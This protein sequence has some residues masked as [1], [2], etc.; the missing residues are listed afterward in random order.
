MVIEIFNKTIEAI[1]NRGDFS[2]MGYNSRPLK[3][4]RVK[5]IVVQIFTIMIVLVTAMYIF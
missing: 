3:I 4:L 1:V 5:I 2:F